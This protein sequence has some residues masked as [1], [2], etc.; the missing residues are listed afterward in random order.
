MGWGCADN[1]HPSELQFSDLSTEVGLDFTHVSGTPQQ[2][3]IIES[4]GGGAAFLDYDGDDY[5][6]LFIVNGTRIA[7]PPPGTSNR[8]FRNIPADDTQG[9]RFDEVTV[10]AGLQ[11]TGWGMGAAA[12][13]TDNDGN[14]DLFVTYLGPNVLY[15]NDGLGA[16]D[17]VT[18]EVGVGDPRWGSS[19]AFG[20]LDADGDLDLYV[21]NYLLF[22]PQ[23]PPNDGKPCS[24]WK[25]LDVFCGP[26][27]LQAQADVLYRNDGVH[28]FV[29]V[30]EATGVSDHQH[31]ALGVLWADLDGDGD[32]DLYVANDSKP[33][34]L[35]RNDGDWSLTEIATFAGA[36]YSE[37]GRSQA[38]MGVASGDYDRDGDLDLYVTN[39][40]DDVNTL[41]QNKG[42]GT[43]TDA[44]FDASLGGE[45]RPYL[46][47]G[48]A[49]FDADND[50]WLDLFVA[51]GHLYPQ[52]MT[53]ASGL[54]YAQH[55]L[56][57]RNIDGRF[58]LQRQLSRLG[59]EQV[60]RG[61]AVGDYDNDG[62]LDLLVMN[63]NAAPTFLR[64]EAGD[65][66]NWLGLQLVGGTSNQDGLGSRVQ[67]FA[68]GES[69]IR[70]V[71]RSYGYQSAHDGRVLFGLGATE[72]VDRVEI[73]WPSG[74]LQILQKPETRRY[75]V[76]HEDGAVVDEYAEPPSSSLARPVPVA[77]AIVESLEDHTAKIPSGTALE[78]YEEGV[79]Y[80]NLGRYEEAL[81]ALHQALL[82]QPEY[83]DA[84]Y[85]MGLVLYS[86]LGRDEEAAA[87]L[88]QVAARDSQRVD[89][90]DL[91]GATYL[92]LNLPAPAIDVLLKATALQPD[93]WQI[94][95][96]LG[97]AYARAERMVLAQK[98]F[99]EASRL[100]PYK[101]QP[102]LNLARIYEA[103]G[104]V[105]GAKAERRLFERWAPVEDRVSHY[106]QEIAQYPASLEG[107]NLLGQAYMK[108]GRLAL[109]VARFQRAVELDSSF[110]PAYYGVGAVMHLRGDLRRA[111]LAYEKAVQLQPHLVLA[112]ADLGQAYHQ[113]GQLDAAIDA[114]HRALML[115]PDLSITW[116]KLGQMYAASDRWSEAI[117]AYQMALQHDSTLVA[118]RNALGGAYATEGQL[119]AA[120]EQWR[121][122]L[123]IAPQDSNAARLIRM[124]E[125]Q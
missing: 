100:A 125:R 89:V 91:L 99:G 4:M 93:S 36:A 84:G 62:D 102:H 11:L 12:G 80:Y 31:P 110:A 64:N 107:H 68:N 82:L 44:T 34:L 14:V 17:D 92:S 61:T 65:R 115:R 96:R 118:T 114:L 16:F 55:N 98:A 27:G 39:F 35:F 95:H 83:D 30:S 87:Q 113:V 47:W 2:H 88:E 76:V 38:G 48:T 32:Q 74:A 1:P 77:G 43:F 22:D 37:D 6:D 104:N 23:F 5:L 26:H 97:T 52:L 78:Y 10:E 13:D 70:E 63:L 53:H 75:L 73:R 109:A 59:G 45:A 123:R 50:G 46:G 19:A 21:A 49:L 57:Y 105:L 54:R 120:I 51:N 20:D 66:N 79:R 69:Q 121:E 29:D 8:L 122:V 28:G 119:D 40:S 103:T 25:G 111:I 71:Q 15:R 56:L 72:Q 60:S 117:H 33:N 112:L 81:A 116:S 9:R 94:H 124:A 18:E 42:N 24:G 106:E 86:G 90:R 3:L 85:T 108:Q 7:D 58:A 101:P 67:L 41:Y